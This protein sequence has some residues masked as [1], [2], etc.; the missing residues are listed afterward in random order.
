MTSPATRCTAAVLYTASLLALVQSS[1]GQPPIPGCFVDRREHRQLATQVCLVTGGCARLT[2]KWCAWQCQSLGF[3]LAGVE[4]S[5]QCA[6]GHTLS[7][8]TMVAPTPQCNMTCTGSQE[9]CGGDLRVWAMNSSSYG[10]TQLPADPKL[11]SRWIPNGRTIEQGGYTCQPY[12]SVFADGLWSCVMTFNAASS[13]EGQPGEHM[14]AM[15][16]TDQ[17]HTWTPFTP[18]EPYSNDTTAQASQS[19][20]T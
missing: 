6:C 1:V 14:I 17:G 9:T 11:D 2:R 4:A 8:P 12:C 18:I 3:E 20:I 16:T 15:R 5:H 13:V 10:P 19:Q 7:L